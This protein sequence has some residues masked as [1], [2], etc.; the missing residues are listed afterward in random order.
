MH[1]EGVRVVASAAARAVA[2]AG[3]PVDLQVVEIAAL[4]HDIDKLQ[5]REGGGRH[6]EVG[7]RHLERLGYPELAPA[8]RSHPVRCLVD[9]E[10]FPRGWTS[11][12]VSLA[13]KHVA[14]EF[15]TIDERLDDMARRHPDHSASIEAA[16]RPAHRL[17]REV[18]DAAGMT[19]EQLVDELRS[20]WRAEAA[21]QL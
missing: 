7:A 4:L 3:I 6:G 21:S 20:A 18:A 19:V 2:S 10:R 12:L 14:Q 13:D 9:E 11:V 1:S 16:R 17:E 5:T 8:V 15:L